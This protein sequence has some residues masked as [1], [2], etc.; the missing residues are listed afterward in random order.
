LTK[1]TDKLAD[2]YQTSDL[3]ILVSTQNQTDFSFLERM[4]PFA[5]FH[6]F[7]ILVINQTSVKQALLSNFTTVRVINSAEKGLSKSRNLALKNAVKKIVLI[8]DDDVVYKAGFDAKIVEAFN[9]NPNSSVIHFQTE[10]TENKLFWSYPEKSKRLNVNRLTNVLSIEI[11]IKTTDFKNSGLLFDELFGLGAQFEDAETFFFLRVAFYKKKE[12]LFYPETIVIH[13]PVT[14]SDEVESDRK[15]Y[16]KMAGFQ[17][18]FGGLSYILLFK[19]IF[20]LVRKSYISFK[21]IK[22][23]FIV[24]LKGIKDYR[25]VSKKITDPK[26]D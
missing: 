13:P 25:T 6:Q 19:Y 10:T 3:E 4:F 24:G 14:S 26:Y 21:E 1:Y 5:P 2:R 17:K 8:A 18:R 20:F 12:V 9:K 15:I 7:H 23:K 11:A 16:A 22:H